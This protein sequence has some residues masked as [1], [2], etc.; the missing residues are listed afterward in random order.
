M[1]PN[2]IPAYFNPWRNKLLDWQSFCL[3]NS[4]KPQH[5]SLSFVCDI[6][7]VNYSIIGVQNCIQLHDSLDGLDNFDM[8]DYDSFACNDT[9]LINPSFWSFS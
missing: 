5:A 1:D 9:K 7:E 4:L 6:P 8:L 2:T 3:H